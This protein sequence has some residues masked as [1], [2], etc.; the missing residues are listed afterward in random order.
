[1]C[2]FRCLLLAVALSLSLAVTGLA[3]SFAQY[4]AGPAKILPLERAFPLD[5]LVELSELRARD[6]VRHARILLGGGG[7]GR[8]SSIGG[9]V[10]FP[11]QGSSD[12]FLVG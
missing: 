1:M 7:G 3:S 8:R 4:A 10:D 6:R 11:V 2:T 9:V 5:E 12:P